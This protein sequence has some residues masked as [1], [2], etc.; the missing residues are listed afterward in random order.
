MRRVR[1]LVL[2]PALVPE[3]RGDYE[4]LTKHS[5]SLQIKSGTSMTGPS[6]S[7]RLPS[8]FL[9][10][11]LEGL[12]A[13]VPITLLRV[14]LQLII[15]PLCG[16]GGALE[17]ESLLTELKGHLLS[18]VGAGKM[19]RSMADTSVAW[20][21]Q[22]RIQFPTIWL[23]DNARPCAVQCYIISGLDLHKKEAL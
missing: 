23:R 15:A 13:Y 7:L 19:Q 6:A 10:K 14:I 4:M 1:P 21:S 20:S 17:R 22:M 5:L 12:C 11:V 8:L 9:S 3:V 2:V 18:V 16:W